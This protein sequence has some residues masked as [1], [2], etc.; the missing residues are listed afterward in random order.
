M[1]R[2]KLAI[3]VLCLAFTVVHSI[4]FDLRSGAMKCIAEDI[5]ANAMAVGH[6]AIINPID[7]S[8]VPKSH[9]ITCHV[10]SPHGADYHTGKNVISGNFAFTA[11]EAGDYMACFSGL[12]QTLETTV[13][14]DFEWKTGVAAKDWSNVAKK[15]QIE[16]MEFELAKM[17]DTVSTIHTEMFHL[18]MREEEMQG[19][20]RST[21]TIMAT[22]GF[23]SLLVCLSVAGLQLWH[24]KSFFERKKLL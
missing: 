20:N 4:R 14:I 3:P 17:Y 13:T 9:N 21:N 19:L 12:D 7:S 10:T 24:L 18:R 15:G 11:F 2:L 16:Y 1:A 8:P 5:A 23:F 6:Y 22:L